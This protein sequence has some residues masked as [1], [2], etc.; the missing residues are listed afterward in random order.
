MF[1]VRFL[2]LLAIR[3]ASLVSRRP[4]V[5]FLRPLCCCGAES[6]SNKAVD[7]KSGARQAGDDRCETLWR[8]P[9]GHHEVAESKFIAAHPAAL[10]VAAGGAN[11]IS[12]LA[13]AEDPA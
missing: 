3:S 13:L 11:G 8:G 10:V 9:V 5:R 1:T 2:S 7:R 12:R 6:T 4:L